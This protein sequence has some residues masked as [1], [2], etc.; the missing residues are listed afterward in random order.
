[1][2]QQEAKRKTHNARRRISDED[3]TTQAALKELQIGGVSTELC[4]Q[5]LWHVSLE[6]GAQFDWGTHATV[7]RMQLGFTETEIHLRNM[8]PRQTTWKSF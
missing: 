5:E 4:W 8:Y 7:A 1:M 6:M 2:M 3:V